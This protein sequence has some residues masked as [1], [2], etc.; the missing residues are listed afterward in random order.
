VSGPCFLTFASDQPSGYWYSVDRTYRVWETPEKIHN[1][2]HYWGA[3]RL[4]KSAD[5]GSSWVELTTR[6][7]GMGVAI[8]KC[9]VDEW[10]RK[11]ITKK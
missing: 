11:V 6:A 10:N 8:R 7:E 4:E 1:D 9:R 5:G 2:G 3:A